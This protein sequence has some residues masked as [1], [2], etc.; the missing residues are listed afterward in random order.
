[1]QASPVRGAGRGASSAP[2]ALSVRRL[3]CMRFLPHARHG[4]QRAA[5]DL[6]EDLST[7]STPREARVVERDQRA[8]GADEAHR[9]RE[10]GF[11][12]L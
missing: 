3:I 12:E 7:C 9:L 4:L 5:S 10:N 2:V 1:M 6:A 11:T 8:T